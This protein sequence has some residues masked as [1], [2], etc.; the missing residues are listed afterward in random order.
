MLPQ[1]SPLISII[2]R[3]NLIILHI[4]EK[5]NNLEKIVHIS[6]KLHLLTVKLEFD[7]I[8]LGNRNILYI[9]VSF[10]IR[11]HYSRKGSE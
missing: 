6:M 7:K 8:F 9:L 1:K 11:E 4:F 2:L 5:I 10:Y 3:I